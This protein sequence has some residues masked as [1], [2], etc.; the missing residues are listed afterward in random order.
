MDL[1]G[2]TFE[3][4]KTRIG[5]DSFLPLLVALIATLLLAPL[6]KPLPLAVTL[7]GMAAQL[8][9]LYAV[10]HDR[11]IRSTVISGISICVPMRL[12]AQLV[13]DQH[14]LLILLSHITTGVY[15]AILTVV[16]LVRVIAH[17]R[18]TSQTVIGAVCGYLMIGY[19]FTYCYLVLT[20]LD[21]AAIAVNGQPLGV[22]GVTNIGEHMAELIYFS[23]ISLTTVGY[24]DVV[25]VCP[26]AR[27]LVVVEI[28]TG[29]L[30]LAAFVARLVGAMSS[31]GSS[32]HL[33]QQS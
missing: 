23:F 20:F 3:T 28:L 16:V 7:I 14:P 24:G 6:A 19:V 13:G 31:P 33:G 29:Q 30:Y 5:Q 12:A 22:E 8:A 10:W 21:P 26:V 2:L 27:T 11:S 17:Q 32:A 25:P 4:P 18:V 1:A 9:G 15:F